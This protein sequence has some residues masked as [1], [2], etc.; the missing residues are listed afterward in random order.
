MPQNGI[1]PSAFSPK[2]SVFYAHIQEG[3]RQK[4]IPLE[5]ALELVYSWGARGVD[6]EYT[7]QLDVSALGKALRSAGFSVSCLYGFYDFLQDPRGEKAF[8]Q[9][10]AALELG[11]GTVM[12][13]PGFYKGD[14][15]QE[16]NSMV[17]AMDTVCQYAANHKVAVAVEDFDHSASPTSTWEQIQALCQSLPLLNVTF[18]TGNFF[19]SQEDPLTAFHALKDR[20]VHVHCKDRSL[21]PVPCKT[22]TLRPD[23][24]AMF[25]SPVGTGCIPMKEIF[26]LLRSQG[27]QGYL[28]AEHF[29]SLCQM[30]TLQKS[31]QWMQEQ[32]QL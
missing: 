26:S 12:L 13:I 6:V 28:T 32:I 17:A 8:P 7:P 22:P 15:E 29:G 19:Y 16:W 2:L 24:T 5:E 30:E 25:S 9:I 11:A 10:Q 14:R 23:G 1:L 31:L 4:E 21:Q 18:D 3:A 20:I 27:Y